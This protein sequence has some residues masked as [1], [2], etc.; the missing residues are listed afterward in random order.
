M[1]PKF[2]GE[3]GL[4]IYKREVG[5][6]EGSLFLPAALSETAKDVDVLF[7]ILTGIAV[8]I[9][10]LVWMLLLIFLVRYRRKHPTKQGLRLYG[11]TRLEIIWTVI[12]ALILVVLGIYSAQ[13]VYALQKPPADAYEIQVTASKWKWEFT[14]PDGPNGGFTTLNDLRLPADKP[15]LF[16]IT[17]TDVIH[18]FWIP[19]LRIKM[20]AVSGRETRVW[21]KPLKEEGKFKVLC[22]EYCG[23]AHA[24]MVSDA[25]VMKEEHFGKWVASGGK[26]DP[27]GQPLDGKQLAQQF[28]CLA[29]HAIDGRELAGPTWKGIYGTERELVDGSKVKVDDEYLKESIVNPNA[30]VVKGYAPS[31]PAYPQLS[32]AQLQ[33]LVD[34]I[35]SLK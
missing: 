14:Y 33:A 25:L 19:E 17:S 27:S 23:T 5:T 26:V 30:K 18:S 10:L 4:K 21:V 24:N 31:M 32:D 34:Y 3:A 22:A 28:G 20:D 7:Y 29:C 11:N 8:V 9:F 12:P 35:K 15:I 1:G 16:R 13:M 2:R 6:V